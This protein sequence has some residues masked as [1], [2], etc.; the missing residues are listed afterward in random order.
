MALRSIAMPSSGLVAKVISSGTPASRRR[1]MSPAQTAGRYRRRSKK[2]C[3]APA[4]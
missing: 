4:A 1:S 3:P 2:V